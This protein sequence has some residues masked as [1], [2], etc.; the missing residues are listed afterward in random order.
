MKNRTHR[1]LKPKNSMEILNRLV[2]MLD[3]SLAR[4][5]SFAR[6]WKRRPYMIFDALARKHGH[7]FLQ[8]PLL[9]TSSPTTVG[10]PARDHCI[11]RR[12][13]RR[14]GSRFRGSGDNGPAYSVSSTVCGTAGR[15][16]CSAPGGGP[17]AGEKYEKSIQH[18]APSSTSKKR[19]RQHSLE[20]Q[21]AA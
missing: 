15:I 2:G 1:N 10:A 3:C 9:G 6:P 17:P 4:Y 20:P 21:S 12:M 13:W 16:D 11:G 5:L 14:A 8:R 18:K 19:V 7:H